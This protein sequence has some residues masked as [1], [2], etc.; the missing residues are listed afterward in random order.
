MYCSNNAV[1]P[2]FI[3]IRPGFC[4]G[5]KSTEHM[6][7]LPLDESRSQNGGMELYEMKCAKRHFCVLQCC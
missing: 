4:G 2:N 3:V 5:I 7:L 1:L 6:A